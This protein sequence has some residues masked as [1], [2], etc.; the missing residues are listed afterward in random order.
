M[1]R[2]YY[3][4]VLVVLT[5]LGI[6]FY[7][8]QSKS[9]LEEEFDV[10]LDSPEKVNDIKLSF[11][12]RVVRL[13]KVNRQWEI[14]KQ[15]IAD[16]IKVDAFLEMLS[17]LSVRNP[18]TGEQG[19]RM[20]NEMT[21]KGVQVILSSDQTSLYSLYSISSSAVMKG[22]FA[23]CEGRKYVVQLNMSDQE[24]GAFTSNPSYWQSKRIFSIASDRIKE[25]FVDWDDEANTFNVK[26]DQGGD[27]RF[28]RNE[29]D[30]TQQ[31]DV[32]ILKYY[33][34]EFANLSMDDMGLKYRDMA[35]DCVC[36][37]S[38]V[39]DNQKKTRVLFYQLKNEDGSEDVNNLVVHLVN[40]EVWGKISYLKINPVIKKADF[41]LLK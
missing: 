2:K 34:Y 24:A 36:E 39:E 1:S 5:T 21:E 27:Y 38:I 22:H 18:I 37:I 12:D 11:G 30:M 19:Q 6:V 31:C 15:G 14:N 16:E 13:N 3:I 32:H 7:L 9:T 26:K 35:G 23:F 4:L 28:I 40:T 41:F 17:S 29:K 8:N 33:T 10:A 20:K 25:I